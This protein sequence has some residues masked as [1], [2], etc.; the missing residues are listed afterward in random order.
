MGKRKRWMKTFSSVMQSIAGCISLAKSTNGTPFIRT[1][2]N[3][4]HSL[5]NLNSQNLD[6][7]DELLGDQ[8]KSYEV[9]LSDEK[10]YILAASAEDAAWYALELSN[11][12]NSQLLDVRLIDG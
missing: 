2:Q 6:G 4:R 9:C 11:D 8:L 5:S 10:I 7:Q 1:W 12:S 3:G